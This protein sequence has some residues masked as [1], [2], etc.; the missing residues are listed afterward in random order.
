MKSRFRHALAAFVALTT[1][2]LA[3][4]HAW[5]QDSTKKVPGHD[6][7][8][9][10][11]LK[12][13][14][15]AMGFDQERTTHHFLLFE[16]GGAIDVSLKESTDTTTLRAVRRHLQQLPEL[17]K[18]GD[19]AKPALTHAQVVPGTAEMTRRRELIVYEYLETPS[20]GRV[21]IVT[22]DRDALAAVHK[23]LR[24]QITDHQTG[25]S[26]LVERSKR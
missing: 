6:A 7:H 18:A 23:F 4:S 13:G 19:F 2:A 3:S 21:Q 8:H 9:R 24:F 10:E 11:M 17:F 20:G 16:D 5:G 1:V 15:T 22:R 25:D 14:A 26:G 12:R